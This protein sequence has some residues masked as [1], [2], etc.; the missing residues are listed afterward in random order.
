MGT[1][2][3]TKEHFHSLQAVLGGHLCTGREAR[4]GAAAG[5]R[6]PGSS[7]EEMPHPRSAPWPSGPGHLPLPAKGMREASVPSHTGSGVSEC[8]QWL[9]CLPERSPG[10]GCQREEA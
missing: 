3:H 1:E 9:L 2:T 10:Q 5:P 7:R 6:G 8:S 4:G